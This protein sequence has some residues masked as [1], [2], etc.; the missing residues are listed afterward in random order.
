MRKNEAMPFQYLEHYK[1]NYQGS[2]SGVNKV[3]FSRAD[4]LPRRLRYLKT[5]LPEGKS[6]DHSDRHG[7]ALGKR[8]NSFINE[9]IAHVSRVFSHHQNPKKGFFII[10]G[11]DGRKLLREVLKA[12]HTVEHLDMVE[13]DEEAA[14]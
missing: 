5:E 8:T 9:M 4:P 11:G 14:C 7:Y 1:R 12:P 10:G 13:I 3:L 6:H 2:L